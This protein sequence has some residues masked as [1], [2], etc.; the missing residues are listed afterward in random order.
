MLLS[1]R[2]PICVFTLFKMKSSTFVMLL[3]VTS[4]TSDN[5]VDVVVDSKGGY[6]VN[7]AGKQWFKSADTF[8]VSN[9][10]QLSVQ[11]GN[12]VVSSIV[13]SSGTDPT[14]TYIQHNISYTSKTG[15]TMMMGI[16]KVYSTGV[17][18]FAQE[19][20][21]GLQ[22][23]NIKGDL[24]VSTSFPSFVLEEDKTFPR[25]VVSF[26]GDQGG[27]DTKTGVF[28][29]NSESSGLCRV[30]LHNKTVA[31]SHGGFDAFVPQPDGTIKEFPKHYCD[32]T[33]TEHCKQWAYTAQ[34][35]L[36]QC[37]A[38]CA[39]LSCACY[40][41]R[42]GSGGSSTIGTGVIGSGP[43][44]VFS[45]DL[46]S[47]V[48]ISAYNN[49]MV[50]SQDIV[51]NSISY[52]LMNTVESIPSQSRLETV[53]VVSSGINKAMTD[54]GDVLLAQYGKSRN[55]YKRDFAMQNLGYS[56]DN[57]AYYYYNTEPG[58]TYEQTL[59]DVKAYAD[60]MN[61]PYKYVLLDSWWYYKGTGNGVAVWDAMPSVFPDG[62]E[63]VLQ[64]TGWPA[65]LHNRFWALNTPYSTKNG[66]KYNFIYD[67]SS[68]TCPDDQ[69]FWDD[70]IGNKTKV[71]MFMYEQD[72]LND[73]FDK[74]KWLTTNFTAART[75]LL[76]MN[77]GAMK[78]NA[79][80][81][82]CMSHVRHLLQ[83]VECHAMT[84]A[85]ASR[86]YHPGNTQWNIGTTSILAHALGYGASKD[87]YWSTPVQN[88]SK[89]GNT[90]MEPHNALESAVQAFSTGPV[91]VSDMIN[92]SNV[93]LIL[94][95]CDAAGRL[96]TPDRHM[97]EIDSVF[98]SMSGLG[99]G[100]VGEVWH[101]YS[102]ISGVLYGYVLVPML[103]D[104][105]SLTLAE[106]GYPQDVNMF[107]M[108][109]T[110][111]SPTKFN[112]GAPL[113]ISACNLSDFHQYTLS[114]ILSNGFAVL[115]EKSKWVSVSSQR[116]VSI[117]VEDDTVKAVLSGP[118]HEMVTVSFVTPDNKVIT[119]RCE[120]PA[121]MV[122]S[123]SGVKCM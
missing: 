35:T 116:F 18:V 3:L 1:T 77:S 106:L 32:C 19:F 88:G 17:V 7:I 121:T 5:A 63:A 38:T 102:N 56:T 46:S 92:G 71:G 21:N 47:S 79:T 69:Q 10:E 110:D 93:S 25:G 22:G 68:C 117:E 85:R 105:Y 31:P 73:E 100:P 9:G 15:N 61:I 55:A 53:L 72:W 20:P 40:D 23:S 16:I 111:S 115:G 122:A 120:M 114:P 108:D 41:F 118:T 8:L 80:I 33:G 70:L 43:V 6:V 76:Q 87:N 123:A 112:N 89:W 50:S 83:S 64:H 107:A 90:T 98:L 78:N 45:S 97:T 37:Q 14:G 34:T 75:W 49:F 27:V 103:N 119:G 52:G 91:A 113:M 36:E 11:Q 86:D 104:S 30:T 39:S 109:Y 59:Y 2:T 67:N 29:E 44:V 101:T 12:L 81:Q 95:A 57:G 62:L 65:Q 84:N 82:Y 96:L 99:H 74:M 60:S 13:N 42:G 26:Q 24:L 66:G 94:R 28:G 48:V 54:W 51:N 4:A 58:K